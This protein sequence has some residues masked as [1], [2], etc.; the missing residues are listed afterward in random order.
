M[1]RSMNEGVT[2]EYRDISP[3]PNQNETSCY[4]SHQNCMWGCGVIYMIKF[5]YDVFTAQLHVSYGTFGRLF[6]FIFPPIPYDL[7]LVLNFA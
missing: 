5:W 2:F 4:A 3:L 6:N 7:L 1:C